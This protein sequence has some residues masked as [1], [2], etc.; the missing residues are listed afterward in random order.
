MTIVYW[1]HNES[2]FTSFMAPGLKLLRLKFAHNEK[3]NQNSEHFE[4]WQLFLFFHGQNF[5][6]NSTP[7]NR[8]PTYIW[9]CFAH[10]LP[11]HPENWPVDNP[12]CLADR[13][14]NA[15][16]LLG[17]YE[18]NSSLLRLP[19]F[20]ETHK[21][22]PIGLTCFVPALHRGVN[23]NPPENLL[24]FSSK[25]CCVRCCLDVVRTSLTRCLCWFCCWLLS[26]CCLFCS[27]SFCWHFAPVLFVGK[28]SLF[29]TSSGSRCWQNVLL[30]P[31]SLQLEP[32]CSQNS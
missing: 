27:G 26:C 14:D 32:V 8:R 10:F 23:Q 20:D 4:T 25:Y 9:T 13:K 5:L 19:L 31:W 24:S 11:G 30:D 21:L 17:N 7:N 2:T 15:M 3:T 16:G 6:S 18:I 29:Q 22:S 12:W 28:M 1:F